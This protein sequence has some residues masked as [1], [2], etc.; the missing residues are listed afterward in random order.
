MTAQD[1]EYARA[2]AQRLRDLGHSTATAHEDGS[3]FVT[4]HYSDLDK[5]TGHG[6]AHLY[7][8]SVEILLR[9][10]DGKYLTVTNRRWGGFSCPGGKI[11]PGEHPEDAMMR[12]FKEETG[13]DVVAFRQVFGGV[14]FAMPKDPGPP[15]FCLAYEVQIPDDQEPRQVEEGTE[16][17]WH[18]ASELVQSGLYPD[19]YRALFTALDVA[20]VE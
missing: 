3:G 8:S 6:I 10:E 12:E 11:D 4:V 20:Y 17:G 1:R 15:W 2:A 18:T 13:L 14:H 5:I 7:R 19:Y 16:I 9:R